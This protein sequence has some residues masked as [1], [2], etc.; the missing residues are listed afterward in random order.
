MSKI[1]G[2]FYKNNIKK[3]SADYIH[4]LVGQEVS[5]KSSNYIN[6]DSS[7][8]PHNPMINTGGILMSSIYR[9]KD[10]AAKRHEEM[11]NEL[12][13]LAGVTAGKKNYLKS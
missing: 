8:R 9:Y 4:S 1:S 11:L 6:L 13:G 10:S 7:G 2:K 3:S 12:K 5:G